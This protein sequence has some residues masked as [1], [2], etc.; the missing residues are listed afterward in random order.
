[1]MF[2]CEAQRMSELDVV[3]YVGEGGAGGSIVS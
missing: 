1:M 3:I 2:G